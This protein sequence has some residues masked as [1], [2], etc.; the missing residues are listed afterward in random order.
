MVVTPEDAYRK[1]P[2][3]LSNECRVA[4]VPETGIAVVWLSAFNVV[5]CFNF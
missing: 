5:D 4:A 2:E 1:V 3:V